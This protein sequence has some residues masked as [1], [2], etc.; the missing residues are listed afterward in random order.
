[1]SDPDFL[2]AKLSSDAPSEL[3]LDRYVAGELGG[4]D[5]QRVD[6]WLAA[7][8]A[9]RA[10]LEAR[11]TLPARLDADALFARVTAGISAAPAP[12]VSL[13]K[14]LA[15]WFGL[16]R[17]GF[18]VVLAAAALALLI[19]RP[20]ASPAGPVPDVVRA[21]GGSG[22]VVHRQADGSSEVL[23][24][25]SEARQGD[26][27]RFEVALAEER[28]VLVID[29]DPSGALATAWPLDGADAA[30]LVPAGK[31]ELDGAV[32]LDGALG[33]EWL[34]AVT[35][36]APLRLADVLARAAG[37]LKLPAGCDVVPIKL[38]KVAR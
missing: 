8:P 5:R 34:H 3:Q 22:F 31:R 23:V 1:M 6:R 20:W 17:P 27:L 19:A 16:G 9:R 30:R 11:R 35:C 15:D 28:F 33:T 25:G 12:R 2:A 32:E 13:A 18:F 4:A 14:R 26:R 7:D 29:Q 10:A 37:E 21:M 36:P 38:L 24:S